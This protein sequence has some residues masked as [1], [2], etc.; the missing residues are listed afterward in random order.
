MQRHRDRHPRQRWCVD[1]AGLQYQKLRAVMARVKLVINLD[2]Q[3]AIMTGGPGGHVDRLA[4]RGA[5]TKL[6]PKIRFFFSCKFIRNIRTII[7]P[8]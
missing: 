1:V 6:D 7:P 3:P 5:G 4:D 2:N 8:R